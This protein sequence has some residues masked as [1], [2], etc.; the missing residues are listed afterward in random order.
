MKHNFCTL[1]S[2]D[3][4]HKGLTL[5]NSLLNYD[6][7]FTLF[8]FC[9]EKD[10]T[11]ILE[12]IGMKNA[13]ITDMSE[14]EAEDRELLETKDSRSVQE[15]S[16]TAKASVMLYVFKHYADID[17]I[18]WLDG[19]T[20]FFSDAG[21]IYREWGSSSILLTEEKY[22]GPYEEKSRIYGKYQLGF[23]G[24]RR[25]ETGI[26]CLE[27]FRSNV[28]QWCY[29][30]FEE[31][32]WS[33]QMYA[34]NWPEKYKKV[35]IVKHK[36]I[37]ANPFILYRYVTEQDMKIICRDSRVC[38]ED[39]EIVLFHFYGFDRYNDREFDL[40]HYG[41][42]LSDD[43][44]KHI[45]KPYTEQINK[46][47]AE[48]NSVSGGY[49][50]DAEIS[51][52]RI[53]NYF[54]LQLQREVPESKIDFCTMASLEY[55]PRCL[56]LLKSLDNAPNGFR[57]WVCCLD[58][59][60]FEAL[61]RLNHESI[62]PV[63][64]RCI[65]HEEFEELLE[66][67]GTK[68]YAYILKGFFIA[69]LLKNNFNLRKLLYLDSDVFLFADAGWVFEALE[70]CSVLLFRN[71][72]AETKADK[73]VL[74]CSWLMGF[75]RDNNT[76]ECLDSLKYNSLWHVRNDTCFAANAHRRIMNNWH[77]KYNGV[78]VVNDPASALEPKGRICSRI[79]RREGKLF[80]GGKRLLAVH[81]TKEV[82]AGSVAS[83]QE[84]YLKLLDSKESGV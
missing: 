43:A 61:V 20:C 69:F 63:Y 54:D 58:E 27:Q 18:I 74:F 36:G 51:G 3:Y 78:R 82:L 5:Y 17:N 38:I 44:L 52:Y 47:V 33:D 67:R 42:F 57:L 26:A 60:V 4:L 10:S 48:I 19:D 70:S 22:T 45:Y 66:A 31:G 9:M 34:V 41:S 55:L 35:Q 21:P 30:R 13:V 37:N 6:G 80:F 39:E 49:C 71:H 79:E 50:R 11:R 24:F 14:L 59:E 2:R 75:R 64:S 32:K 76:F 15:Y 83:L 7:H 68:A 84:N 77:L 23:M 73:S 28:L 65:G 1:L 16:W 29:N 81:F 62:R 56:A 25:D 46:A 12:Q 40:C 53:K 72:K 8:I